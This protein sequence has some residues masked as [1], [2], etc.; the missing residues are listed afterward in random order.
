M[1]IRDKISKCGHLIK[2]VCDA[3]SGNFHVGQ[4]LC[5]DVDLYV[6]LSH[7]LFNDDKGKRISCF[8]I[9]DDMESTVK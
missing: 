5:C 2:E 6:G 7:H 8:L 9:E 4:Y 1:L 3:E